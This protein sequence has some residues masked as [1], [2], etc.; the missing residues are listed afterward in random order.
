MSFLSR[1]RPYH[2]LLAWS[3]YWILLLAVTFGP[4]MPAILRATRA[5]DNQGEIN[6]STSGTVLSI[7]VKEMGQITWTGSVHLLTAALWIAVPPLV[8][9]LFWMRSRVR[10]MPT[11]TQ[12]SR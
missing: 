9:W 7:T 1:W 4:A 5:G 11:F 12:T 10:A 8:I 2:L 3:A 6:A